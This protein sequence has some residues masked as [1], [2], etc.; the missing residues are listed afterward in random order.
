MKKAFSIIP[1]AAVLFCGIASAQEPQDLKDFPACKY[2]NMNRAQYAH[3]RVLVVYDDGTQFG[4]C[5][6]HCAAVDLA[7][8]LDKSPTA[9]RVGDYYSKELIDAETAYWVIGGIKIGVMTKRGKWAFLRKKEA[10]GF[11]SEN[12]GE[13]ATFDQALKAAYEDM[14]ADSKMIRGKRQ[15]RRMQN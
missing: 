4:A 15:I 7:I 5:S 14:Y 10:E 6:I 8:N 2:C 11:I 1:F 3:S 12:G 9:I 13:M